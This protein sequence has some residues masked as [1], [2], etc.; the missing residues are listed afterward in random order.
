MARKASTNGAPATDT[1]KSFPSKVCTMLQ[2][3]AAARKTAK[4]R[5]ETAV[6]NRKDLDE[7]LNQLGAGHTDRHLDVRSKMV[8]C[9][10]AIKWY[11]AR[12]RKL[13]DTIDDLLLAP[14]QDWLWED[15]PDPA[16]HD[17]QES[18]LF[19]AT[20]DDDGEGDVGAPGGGPKPARGP[21]AGCYDQLAALV[22]GRFTDQNGKEAVE[23]VD[24]AALAD[25]IADRAPKGCRVQVITS[26]KYGTRVEVV[27]KGDGSIV[28]SWQHAPLAPGEGDAESTPKRKKKTPGA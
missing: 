16:M 6:G 1:V 9:L 11:R 5:L 26:E 25:F 13:S 14:N 18:W 8:I 7:Q 21:T 3:Y 24:A 10:R 15:L 4:D 20:E 12:I 22:P 2:A 19:S 27:Q 17:P 23:F 28:S